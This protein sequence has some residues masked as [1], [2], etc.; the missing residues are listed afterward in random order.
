MKALNRKSS[1]TSLPV[2]EAY[3]GGNMTPEPG[4]G[5][6]PPDHKMNVNNSY[7]LSQTNAPRAK[8]VSKEPMSRD[9]S[10]KSN[11][12]NSS[13]SVFAPSRFFSLSRRFAK[14]RFSS[15]SQPPPP[16]KSSLTAN[17][18]LN[19]SDQDHKIT[20][21]KKTKQ[22]AQSQMIVPQITVK[23]DDQDSKKNMRERA[24]SPSR[25]LRSLRPRSPFSKS[26]SSKSN[27][28]TGATTLISG[29]TGAITGKNKSFTVGS[30]DTQNNFLDPQ[31]PVN[32][33]QLL[34]SASYH[35]SSITSEQSPSIC[36]NISNNSIAN[37]FIRAT[38]A[39]P[40]DR[41]GLQ[42]LTPDK[43][44]SLSCEFI[45]NSSISSMANNQTSNN[46]LRQL[47]E[48]LDEYD[49]QNA[50]N[51]SNI[52]A[53]S[54]SNYNGKR[55]N[56][57]INIAGLTTSPALNSMSKVEILRKNFSEN[58]NNS[59]QNSEI[60]KT[61]KFKEPPEKVSPD[62]TDS[63]TNSFE[64]S[65][66]SINDQES[67]ETKLM[68]ALDEA[69]QLTEAN[70][71]GKSEDEKLGN[72]GGKKSN[73]K[74]GANEEGGS[75][76]GFLS[77]QRLKTSQSTTNVDKPPKGPSGQLNAQ[78]GSPAST[79]SG[80]SS[81][82]FRN[83]FTGTKSKTIDFPDLLQTA[84][85]FNTA[86]GTSKGPTLSNG[87]PI[88]SILRRSETPPSTK[89]SIRQPSIESTESTRETS[90]EKLLKSTSSTS[91]P[92]MFNN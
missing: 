70:E 69:I 72:I 42:V 81:F 60:V 64:K 79:A 84:I 62:Q 92:L 29:T 26:R 73:V 28:N 23:S 51:N 36:S 30:N 74:F 27:A 80:N 56:K 65:N 46:K 34:M 54:F 68:Q 50:D 13:T 67:K 76:I 24:L 63:E 12:S 17:S 43:L 89:H 61:V 38:T 78:T 4:R 18:S 66:L 88:Q 19:E 35:S 11:G 32:R 71:S 90:I 47:N 45:D 58:A 25:L 7:N 55:A 9:S 77:Q 2:N 85:E 91:R 75:K 83:K 20:H 40:S 57:K 37:R 52:T 49:E 1:V 31:S 41:S 16:I 5:S 8:S 3:Q 86:N 14:I 6:V 10:Q 44:R 87:K 39:G 48:T 21:D 53:S 82:G 59:S 22:M 33:N 15:S